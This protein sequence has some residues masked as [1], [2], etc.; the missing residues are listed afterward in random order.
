[1]GKV[2]PQKRKNSMFEECYTREKNRTQKKK[3]GRTWEVENYESGG[4]QGGKTSSEK[5]CRLL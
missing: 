1:M 3:A 2:L 4:V 5:P